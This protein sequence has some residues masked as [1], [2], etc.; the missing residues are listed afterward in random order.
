MSVIDEPFEKALRQAEA[1]ISN[2]NLSGASLLIEPYLPLLTVRQKERVV[3]VLDPHAEDIFRKAYI[4]KA[5][6]REVSDKMLEMLAKDGM[7]L[8]PSVRKA[9]KL[10]SIG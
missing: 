1:K 2:G 9:L 4:L 3:S 10:V 8:L 7:D 6:D 5:F